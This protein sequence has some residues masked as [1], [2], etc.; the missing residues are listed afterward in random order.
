MFL[1]V[2]FFSLAL[3]LFRFNFKSKIDHHFPFYVAFQ[4]CIDK[5]LHLTEA[6][7]ARVRTNFC[8]DKILHGSNLRLHETPKFDGAVQVRLVH[9]KLQDLFGRAFSVS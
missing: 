8:T 1:F 4:T 6:A 3:L 2:F 9:K 7:F 5:K